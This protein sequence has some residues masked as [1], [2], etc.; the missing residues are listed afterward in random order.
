MS[1]GNL[2]AHDFVSTKAQ[3]QAKNGFSK[4]RVIICR[5]WQGFASKSQEPMLW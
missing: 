1:R 4:K 3:Q 2:A 5:L